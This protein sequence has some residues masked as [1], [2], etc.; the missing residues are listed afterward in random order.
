MPVLPNPGEFIPKPLAGQD[1]PW[2]F[3]PCVSFFLA[4]AVKKY[5]LTHTKNNNRL[6]LQRTWRPGGHGGLKG[7]ICFKFGYFWI[8][9]VPGVH[10]F[11]WKELQWRLI[12][13]KL[14]TVRWSPAPHRQ[15]WAVDLCFLISRLLVVDI[16]DFTIHICLSISVSYI[17][18]LVFVSP[19][20]AVSDLLGYLLASWLKPI[21]EKNHIPETTRKWIKP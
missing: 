2:I 15:L 7:L 18:V 9:F 20:K 3:G 11:W 21:S 6:W 14:T 10:G 17:Y 19:P 16:L 5:E 4:S 1:F 13:N 8:F 12:Q